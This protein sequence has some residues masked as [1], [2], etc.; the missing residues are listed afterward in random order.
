MTLTV[1]ERQIASLIASGVSRQD[2]PARLCVSYSTV[3]KHLRQL[4]DKLDA[5]SFSALV[6]R[7]IE[8]RDAAASARSTEPGALVLHPETPTI[9]DASSGSF[10]AARNFDELFVALHATLAPFGAT[11]LV[12]SHVRR[13]PDGAVEH[14]SSRWS[15]PEGVAYDMSIPAEE[16]LSFK[17]AFSGET[18]VPL[19]LE[20]MQRSEIY[21]F[22][23]AQIRAQNT[24]FLSAGLARG[25]T[26]FL[27]G[28]AA[29]DRLITSALFQNVTS[30]Q[31][32]AAVEQAPRML[33]TVLR[34][35]NAHLSLA[36]NA[37]RLPDK[38]AQLVML[39]AD[40]L[41]FPEAIDRL[42]MSR[43]AA[44]RHLAIGREVFGVRSNTALIARVWQARTEPNLPF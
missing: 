37:T 31:F 36:T 9:A 16:N 18:I 25:I 39:M 7:S 10:A 41:E 3:D 4:K 14:L 22:V 30:G 38:T 21:D 6:V 1:R 28:I 34:F 27:P 5:P 17:M 26:F 40:G 15:L 24:R 2:L 29:S 19:D 12:H 43:R 11:H 13:R 32:G 35:R 23:P 8:W 33:E 20:A 42:G 44:D